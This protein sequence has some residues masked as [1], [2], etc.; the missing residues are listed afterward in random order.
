MKNILFVFGTRPEVIKLYPLIKIF[1]NDKA[2]YKVL[3]C[4]VGQHKEM[5]DDLIKKLDIRVD[6]NFSVMKKNQS[7]SELSS[8]IMI[9]LENHLSDLDL[10]YIFSIGDTLT[11]FYTALYSYQRQ[12]KFCHIEAG[13]RTNN[14]FSPW[15][16][17]GYRRMISQIATLHFA[18][19]IMSKENLL[20]ENVKNEVIF[21]TGNTVIDSLLEVANSNSNPKLDD[22]I[23]DIINS[24]Y[25][26]VT[27]H[28]RENI[29]GKLNHICNALKVVAKKNKDLNIIFP[30]HLNP[31]VRNIVFDNL[32]GIPN[33]F[34]I[35]PIEYHDFVFLMKKAYLIVTDSG[36]IQEEA[37]SLNVPVLVIRDTTERQDA[38]DF[39]T[40]ELIGC[41]KNQIIKRIS[42]YL[43]EK[44][45]YNKMANAKNPYG[46]G[47]AAKKI[48]KII[49]ER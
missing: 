17:E 24:K 32:K 46:D 3:N 47:Y 18:P 1:S 37:P 20:K 12:I 27:S 26:L 35:E 4:N 5:V 15:P 13:L 38:L 2:N 28:R 6:Y 43:N 11:A 33:V 16:E 36:G 45:I 10:D 42:K 9:D 49:D 25:I 41:E 44:E 14:L 29:G 39:G 23:L 7:L 31:N 8:K 21:I 40:I 34:L 48:K 30:V 19:T 22:D